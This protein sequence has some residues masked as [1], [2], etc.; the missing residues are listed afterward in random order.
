MCGHELARVIHDPSHAKIIA[1]YITCAIIT[2]NIG[3]PQTATFAFFS[4]PP[5]EAV[6]IRTASPRSFGRKNA[7][8]IRLRKSYNNI[9]LWLLL[10]RILNDFWVRL[11]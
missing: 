1:L 3:P 9:I 2:I 10:H 7:N 6:P 8:L 11:G 4:R 5:R